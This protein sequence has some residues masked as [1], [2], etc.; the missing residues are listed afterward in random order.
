[1]KRIS[2]ETFD[3]C[4][5]E[6]MEEFDMSLEEAIEDATS[7]FES[8][9]VD[10]STIM[11]HNLA[12]ATMNLSALHATLADMTANAPSAASF[13]AV[14][15]LKQLQQLSDFFEAIPEAKTIAGRHNAVHVLLLHSHCPVEDVATLALQLLAAMCTENT[16]NQ[17]FVGQQGIESLVTLLQQERKALVLPTLT[18][19]RVACAKHE[20]NKAH[21]SKA[22]GLP[23]VCKLL[24]PAEN[25]EVLARQLAGLLRVVTINDDP[26]ATMS[27]AHETVKALVDAELIPYIINVLRQRVHWNKTELLSAWLAVLKQLAITEDHCKQIHEQCSGLEVLQELMVV[28][29]RQGSLMKRCIMVF[30]NVAAADDV[31]GYLMRTGCAERILNAMRIHLAQASLQQHACATLA[32]LALR[33]P[34]NSKSL[35]EQGAARQIALAMRQHPADVAVLRQASLAIRNMVARCVELRP[36]ILEEDI[37]QV[38]RDA[39]RYRGCGDE[40]YGAL[41]DLGCDIKLATFE[42]KPKAKFNPVQVQSNQ[43]METV[44]EAAEAPFAS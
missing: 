8:Q 39:Q 24:E 26:N 36:R 5:R 28:H 35:V 18:C 41:R 20:A 25:D 29:E 17:D 4:V 10:L 7:Q 2:Q 13:D 14:V 30:R 32:A 31:K 22:G 21:F 23:V 11:T 40:A 42:N 38:L 3:E 27:Q 34:E 19:V 12:N 43:L 44:A 33:S 37:E 15:A 1:M 16:D 6:N 9:G